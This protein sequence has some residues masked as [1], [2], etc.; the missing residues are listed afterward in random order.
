MLYMETI[1][2]TKITIDKEII[3]NSGLN[4]SEFLLLL[5]LQRQANC[6]DLIISLREKNLITKENKVTKEGIDLIVNILMESENI[7]EDFTLAK[8]L[9]DI[10]PKGKKDGTNLYWTE[11][12]ALIKKR[13]A[14][15]TKKYGSYSSNDIIMATKRYI[16][17]FNGDYRF[18]KTLKYF[19][20]K[21]K[22]SLDGVE[23]E[24][25]LLTYLENTDEVETNNN[26][27]NQ[28]V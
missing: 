3:K 11:G 17:S 18:M 6:K 5:L 9:K 20:F 23:S 27:N 13:L 21:E 7:K 25:D 1:S 10:F 24:S 8:Q 22:K 26:W 2:F 15:F 14:I 19:I 28:L 16:N 12:E 4:S